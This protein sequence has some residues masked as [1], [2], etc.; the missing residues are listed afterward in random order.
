MVKLGRGFGSV[1]GSVPVTGVNSV[2]RSILFAYVSRFGSMYVVWL[3]RGSV[4][5]RDLLEVQSL[6]RVDVLFGMDLGSRFGLVS[7]SGR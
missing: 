1:S 5:C 7:R 6:V 2:Q 4:S 3:V